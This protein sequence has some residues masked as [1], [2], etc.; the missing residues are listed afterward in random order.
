MLLQLLANLR[1]I[2]GIVT[3]DVL[4]VGCNSV[5]YKIGTAVANK[6][7][8]VGSSKLRNIIKS[9]LLLGA[10]LSQSREFRDLFEDVLTKVGTGTLQCSAAFAILAL[11]Q[12]LVRAISN[13]SRN[14]E[15]S[16]VAD[17][18]ISLHL[19]CAHRILLLSRLP[20]LWRTRG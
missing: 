5:R 11:F 9:L 6:L 12:T 19:K 1:D 7:D 8:P 2:R 16:L 13:P 15:S 17:L 4:D 10:N 14:V 3:G 20:S 18:C